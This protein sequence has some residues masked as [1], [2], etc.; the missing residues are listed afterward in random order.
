MSVAGLKIESDLIALRETVNAQLQQYVGPQSDCPINL[1]E[2]MAYSLLAGGKR[3]RPVLV[4]LTCKACG[5]RVDV[6]LPAACAIE[7]VHTYSL[8]HDDLPAMDN[9]DYRRGRLTNHKVYGEA[10]AILA[11]DALLTLAFEVI[12]RDIRPGTVA[13]ACCADLASASGWCGMVAGQV[14]DL[15][16]EQES[17]NDGC[18]GSAGNNGH[19]RDSKAALSQLEGIHRRKTGRLLC[20]AVTMGA[21]I[22]QADPDLIE[23]LTQF[24]RNVGLAFQIADDL[25]DVTGDAAKLGKNVGKDASLGKMTYPGLLGIEGSR[26]KADDLIHDACRLLEPLG[27]K[28][29]PLAELARFVTKRD[30]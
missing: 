16:A 13:A 23:R 12:A 14:A 2:S 6:A 21:R 20:S 24:G 1:R 22:A 17:C 29:M 18:N 30:H 11:G 8:I 3:L 5:G 27:D 25:L 26:Q 28:A 9:D 10:M 7:M 4:L 15:E 19:H